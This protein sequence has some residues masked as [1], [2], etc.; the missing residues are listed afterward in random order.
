MER[1]LRGMVASKWFAPAG[2]LLLSQWE[3]W[4]AGQ[5]HPSGP[6]WVTAVSCAAAALMLVWRRGAPLPVQLAAVAVTVPPWLFWGAPQNG[7]QFLIGLVATYAVGRWADRPAAFLGIPVVIGWALSQLA[8]DPLQGSVASGWGWALWGVGAWAAGAWVRQHAELEVRRDG[9]REAAARAMLAEQRLDIARDLHDV[10]ANSL[11][12]VIVHAEAAEA[13]VATDPDRAAEAMRRVQSTGRDALRDVRLL[14]GVL[15]NKPGPSMKDVGRSDR[16]EHGTG[17]ARHKPDV[18]DIDELVE[19]MRAAGLRL[20]YHREGHGAVPT[21]I[22]QVI[23]R[24]VQ[25]ALSNVV[26]HA[27]LVATSVLLRVEPDTLLVEVTNEASL[28]DEDADGRL[29]DGNGLR[30][31]QER[32]QAVGGTLEVRRPS[33]GGLQVRAKVPLA[34]SDVSDAATSPDL[35]VHRAAVERPR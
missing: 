31:M 21:V 22:G 8:L 16:G 20:S 13:L 24:L 6:L 3:I 23:Y 17:I 11:G 5:T 29:L 28:H 30:G 26:R 19:R 2:L 34:V 9:Q 27:G 1:G 18:D 14:L 15:R 32:L 12:V 4:I 10:L 25:E 35:S 7:S 33:E